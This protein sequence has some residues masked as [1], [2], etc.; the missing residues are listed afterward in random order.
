MTRSIGPLIQTG[1]IA[2]VL[3]QWAKAMPPFTF[4]KPGEGAATAASMA[5]AWMAPWS[6]LLPSAAGTAT[7]QSQGSAPSPF[8]N[9]ASLMFPLQAMS[10][11]WIDI[12]GQLAGTTPAQLSAVFDRT[13]GALSDALG[14]SPI[15]KLQA[16]WQDLAAAAIAQQEARTKYALLVQSAFAQGLQRLI[17]SLADKANSGERIDSVLALLKLWATKTE[18]VVHETLQSEAGLAATA[19]LTRSALSHRKKMQNVAAII[20]DVLD[21]ATR[22]E[23]DDAYREI[24]AL[25]R[26]LR[27]SRAVHAKGKRPGAKPDAGSR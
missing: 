7:T 22:R 1:G 11:P 6:A 8:A 2:G 19:A 10:Q 17:A 25:K 16:A 20:A 9:P 4:G 3:D 13:Y 18:E 15:R 5:Q 26:E 21:M 12:A 23:L 27:A 14:L 24:Q